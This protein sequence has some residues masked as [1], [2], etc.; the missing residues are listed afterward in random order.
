MQNNDRSNYQYALLNM[1]IVQADFGCYDEA[2]A[3]MNE[4]IATAR[5]NKD[6]ICLNYSLSWLYQFRSMNVGETSKEVGKTMLGSEGHGFLYLKSIA[7]EYGMHSIEIST[8]LTEA[9]YSMSQVSLTSWTLKNRRMLKKLQ[10]GHR[11][12][13][14]LERTY[15]SSH[16]LIDYRVDSLK[17]SQT[18]MQS[19][20]YARLG[21]YDPCTYIA[22]ANCVAGVTSLS[23]ALC[24]LVVDCYAQDSPQEDVIRS[25]CRTAYIV[26]V[27][28]PHP[29]TGTN[30]T[31]SPSRENTTPPSRP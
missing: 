19:S 9:R 12:L 26:S 17:A 22:S 7:R 15:E 1:A 16:L 29:T 30:S 28:S 25:R 8:L 18:L 6:M 5:E 3:A 21:I 13:E 31:S 23:N 11:P 4:T 14:A 10:Q 27:S 2:V 24:N 20:I